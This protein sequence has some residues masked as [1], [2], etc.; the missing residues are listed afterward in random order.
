MLL[1]ILT[2]SIKKKNERFIVYEYS[3]NDNNKSQVIARNEK[4]MICTFR[5]LSKPFFR[6]I[7]LIVFEI[8]SCSFFICKQC[9]HTIETDVFSG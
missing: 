3:E 7:W 6:V 5:V 9:I 8:N 1:E 4:S 2:K